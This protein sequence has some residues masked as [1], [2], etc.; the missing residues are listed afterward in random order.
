MK[1]ASNFNFDPSIRLKS[2]P[3]S[4]SGS[5][6]GT[7]EKSKSEF[8]EICKS[9]SFLASDFFLFFQKRLLFETSCAPCQRS[10]NL[11]QPI[12]SVLTNQK[13]LY[14]LISDFLDYTFMTNFWDQRDRPSKK[15]K[16]FRFFK[17]LTPWLFISRKF[18]SQI[19]TSSSSSVAL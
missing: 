15:V 5:P 18:F 9:Y 2:S 10:Q 13:S 4:P 6:P 8:F 14:K 16:F 3:R 12:K 11:L 7:F 17:K 1:N 19:S